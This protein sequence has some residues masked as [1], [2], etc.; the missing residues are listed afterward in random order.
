MLQANP[1]TDSFVPIAFMV[2]MSAATGAGILVLMVVDAEQKFLAWR[3]FQFRPQCRNPL[4]ATQCLISVTENDGRY[5]KVPRR[6]LLRLS[7][8]I[9]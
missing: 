1:L 9:P 8:S 6:S 3:H 7:A 5:H 4:V 2:F